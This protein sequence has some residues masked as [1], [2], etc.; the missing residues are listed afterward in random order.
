MLFWVCKK[1]GIFSAL[2]TNQTRKALCNHSELGS[3]EIKFRSQTMDQNRNPILSKGNRNLYCPYYRNCLDYAVKLQWEYWACLDCQH[4]EEE[5]SLSDILHFPVDSDP[6]F[7]FPR[8]FQKR[9]AN[10]SL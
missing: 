3:N 2:I 8:S 9:A 6:Y 4:K 10:V 7:T 5:M 1:F